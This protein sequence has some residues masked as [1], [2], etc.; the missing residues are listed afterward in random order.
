MHAPQATTLLLL[1]YLIRARNEKVHP[2]DQV[3]MHAVVKTPVLH[4]LYYIPACP[5]LPEF[6][7]R[8]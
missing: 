5:S 7:G 8:S 6:R 3:Q 1:P 2:I 4:Y